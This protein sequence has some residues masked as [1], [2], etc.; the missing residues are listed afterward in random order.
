MRILFIRHA[1][2]V[3]QLQ[4]D[5]VVG[6]SP[7][8]PLTEKGIR[9][10]NEVAIQLKKHT[11]SH[12]YSSPCIRAYKTAEII[13]HHINV[14]VITNELLIERSHGDFEKR[15]KSD[16]YTDSVVKLIHMDQFRWSP[17]NGESLEDVAN[18][19][20]DFIHDI[21]C[22]HGNGTFLFVTHLMV[23]WSVFYLCTKCHHS[24]L[25]HL[26]TDN[27]SLVEINFEMPDRFNLIR[28]NWPLLELRV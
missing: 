6:R 8:Y 27:C 12:L 22:G 24:I 11:I 17:P 21:E 5:I 26:K 18:R 13:S 4:K 2:S 1:Q 15:K 20:T 14:P 19:I 28:W 25:P 7:E 23:L 3:S 10:S 9:Q 16:V